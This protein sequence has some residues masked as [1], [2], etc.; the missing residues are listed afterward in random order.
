MMTVEVIVWSTRAAQEAC[1]TPGCLHAC[2]PTRREDATCTLAACWLD[3]CP[4]FLKLLNIR[5]L[6]VL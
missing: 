4:E 1:S 5:L 6:S 3:R 2:T